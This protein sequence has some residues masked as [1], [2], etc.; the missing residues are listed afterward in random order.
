MTDYAIRAEN[1]SKRFRIGSR[2]KAG[3]KE[4]LVQRRGR[5]P[6]ALDLWALRDAT[7]SVE[8]GDAMGIIGHNGS[9]KSTALKVLAGIYR[10]TSGRVEVNGRVAALL[11]LGAG[12]HPELTGRENIVLNGTLLGLNRRE[13]DAATEEIIDFSGI[14]NFIDTPVKYYSSGMYVRLG[15]AIA[16]QV[17][18]EILMIDE[19]LA[20]GDE[21]F[22]RKCFDYLSSLRRDGATVLIDPMSLEYMKGCWSPIRWPPSRRCARTHCGWRPAR[23]VRLDRPPRSSRATW[24]RSTV[25]RR[26]PRPSPIPACCRGPGD[27]GTVASW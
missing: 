9:G 17:R 14:A 25:R 10:P 15:F 11:E 22:Q 27:A 4:R 3:L 20:V 19:I 16:V 24:A 6:E 13:I 12:F 2:S 18:P 5:R 8:R 21:E 26:W 23:S 7:F 1:V